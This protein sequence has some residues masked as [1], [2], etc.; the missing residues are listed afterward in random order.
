MPKAA[1]RVHC[2]H[3]IPLQSVILFACNT[4]SFL[5]QASSKVQNYFFSKYR[6]A[7]IKEVTLL[8]LCKDTTTKKILPPQQNPT[9]GLQV[10]EAHSQRKMGYCYMGLT[11]TCKILL[12]ASF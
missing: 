6:T 1:G 2:P 4:G 10:K 8:V 3:K 11:N 7:V 9:E 12:V 5:F